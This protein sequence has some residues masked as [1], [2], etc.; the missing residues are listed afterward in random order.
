MNSPQIC[1]E[2]RM[3]TEIGDDALKLFGRD[4]A[5]GLLSGPPEMICLDAVLPEQFGLFLRTI[6]DEWFHHDV[7]RAAYIRR[8]LI[9]DVD[10]NADLTDAAVTVVACD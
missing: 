5:F 9:D 6:Y 7:S 2:K 8:R 4:I 1:P 3:F 10:G